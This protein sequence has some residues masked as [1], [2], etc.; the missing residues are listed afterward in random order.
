MG[1]VNLLEAARSLTDFRSLVNVTTDKVYREE[2]TPLRGYTEAD[3]LGGPDPYSNSKSCS[4]FVTSCY[5]ESFFGEES[6][7]AISTA[8][9]GNV[10][11]GGDTSKDRILP[12]CVRAV[13]AGETILIRNPSSVRP[14][15]H[16][17]ECLWG[18]LILAQK[19]AEDKAAYAGSYN[20]GPSAADSI[21]TE[22]LVKI[23][24]DT[25]GE[26]ASWEAKPDGGPAETKCLLLDS[27]HAA[28]R[29]GWKPT[30]DI[31]TAI[32]KTIQWEQT[33]IDGGRD[34]AVSVTDTQLADFAS[35]RER[36]TR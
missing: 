27:T 26:R 22:T 16:V 25:W 19:Q 17:L 7:P 5:R 30:W 10:I 15:Q 33:E 3:P 4:E 12:D 6:A 24:C 32:E 13:R 9:S 18:Y 8:R 1:T 28:E 36:Q 23:F 31:R 11:G 2:K 20:F 21:T 35:A 29:L 14:Y 34:A